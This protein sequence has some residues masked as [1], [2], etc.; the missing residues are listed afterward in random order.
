MPEG[1]LISVIIPVYNGADFLGE[2]V[3]SI[4][5]QQHPHTEVIMID[6]GSTDHTPEVAKAIVETYRTQISIQYHRQ[7]NQGPSASRNTGILRASGEFI[8]FLDADDLFP[9]DKFAIQLRTFDNDPSLDLVAGRIQYVSL[10]GAEQRDVK[11][12]PDDQALVHV[13]LGSM[14]VRHGV[15][16]RIGLFDPGLRYSEDVEWWLRIREVPLHFVILHDITLQYRLHANNMTRG[17]TG[18]N[19]PFLEALKKSLARRRTTGNLHLKT[20][21]EGMEKNENPNQEVT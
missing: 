16:D 8:A 11:Y 1:P 9:A 4:I 14:L 20:M 3:E 18:I 15:F 10:E 13:H 5:A 6:D 21:S 17:L 12:D 2:A 7:E 19:R